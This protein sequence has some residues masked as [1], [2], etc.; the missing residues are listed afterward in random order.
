MNEGM[1]YAVAAG[2]TERSGSGD[3]ITRAGCTNDFGCAVQQ[4]QRAVM[5]FGADEARVFALP[6][7]GR[8]VAVLTDIACWAVA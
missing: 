2:V 3:V 7:P 6:A 8:L 5:D 1:G 4:A